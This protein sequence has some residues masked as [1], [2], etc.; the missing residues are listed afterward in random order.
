MNTKLILKYRRQFLLSATKCEQLNN[1]K[2]IIFGTHF[3][4]VH[5]ECSLNKLKTIDKELILIGYCIQP[6]SVGKTN[7]QILK[8]ISKFSAIKE[9]PKLIY[10]LSGRFV[11]MISF[12]E[13][14]YIFN[15]ACGLRQLFYL[16]NENN[17]YAASQPLLLNLVVKLHK[18]RNWDEYYKSRYVKL[19][20]EHHLPSGISL[21]N[22]VFQ[23]V[24]NHYLNVI[25]GKQYRFWPNQQKKEISIEDSIKKISYLLENSII[26]ANRRFKLSLSLTSGKDSRIMLSASKKII[27]DLYIYTLKYRNLTDNSADLLIPKK[28]AHKLAFKHHIIDCTVPAEKE[29]YEIYS[30]NSEPAHWDDWG[31]IANAMLKQYPQD[32]V[33]I[34]GNCVEIGRCTYYKIGKHKKIHSIKQFYPFYD[35]S[36]L[37]FIKKR[38]S[39]WYDGIEHIE[40]DYGYDLFDFFYWEHRMGNWQAQSQLEWDIVQE[41]FTPFNNREIIDTMLAVNPMYRSKPKFTFFNLLIKNMWIELLSEPTNPSLFINKFKKD[42]KDILIYFNIR[43]SPNKIIYRIKNIH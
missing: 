36:E 29:F 15:D 35:G 26:E 43:I 11:L 2:R 28:L 3:L 27:N 32:R 4:Y 24:P 42:I 41:V 22:G 1:W 33:V 25:E 38:L 18:N 6:N 21:F 40:R 7:K 14:I 8:D 34:K 12:R 13:N 5:P 20:K 19:N 16:K 37:D 10:S 23:L 31:K 9:I 17:F 30:Q 39:E